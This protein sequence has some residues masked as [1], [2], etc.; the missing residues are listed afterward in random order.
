MRRCEQLLSGICYDGNMK[1]RIYITAGLLAAALLVGAGSFFTYT[2]SVPRGEVS[3]K[4]AQ[5]VVPQRDGNPPV[6]AVP[7][8]IATPPTTASAPLPVTVRQRV[9]FLIQAPGGVWSSPVFQG[10][11][12][13]AS[14][15]MADAWTRD[16]SSLDAVTGKQSIQKVSDRAEHLFGK[17]TYDTSV[18]DTLKLAHVLFPRVGISA[19]MDVSLQTIVDH[20]E[21]GQLVIAP[22]DGRA[23][24]NPHYTAPGPEHHML[25]I[26]GYDV[27]TKE[28]ITNDPGTR[29]GE[30]YRY[31]EQ[32]LYASIRDYPTGDHLPVTTIRK[33]ILAISK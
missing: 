14:L 12:E 6:E 3:S 23:L 29:Y 10:G 15:I 33:D 1:Y 26:I 24:G 28:F 9:P 8:G 5:E 2:G 13:E 32:R 11:C 7:S 16:V 31:P 30:G 18:T 19:E 21:R 25:V 4:P 20:V 22:M 27:A 17:G